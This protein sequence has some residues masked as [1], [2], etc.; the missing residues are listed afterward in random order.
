MK[1]RVA[2]EKRVT[3]DS[4]ILTEVRHTWTLWALRGGQKDYPFQRRYQEDIT[5]T[6][7][8][9]GARR[10]DFFNGSVLY[11]AGTRLLFG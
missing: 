3:D 5:K 6:V 4:S 8:F 1:I 2:D 9:A 10:N 11:G 7:V